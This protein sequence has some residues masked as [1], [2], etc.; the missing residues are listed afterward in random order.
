MADI[1][2]R[3]IS[4]VV[5]TLAGDEWSP[6]DPPTGPSQRITTA[7]QKAYFQTLARVTFSNAA[8]TLA[9]TTRILAQVG[10]LSAARAVTL[11]AANAVP[12]GTQI[13][14]LDESGT[15]SASNTL[16]W[17]RAGS[18]TINGGAS[19]VVAVN[20]AYGAGSIISDGTSKWTTVAFGG[21]SGSPGPAGP[22]YMT[23]DF[24]GTLAVVVGTMR[25]RIPVAATLLGVNAAVSLAPTGASIIVD[26]NKNG[27]TVFTTQGNRPTIAAAANN[28][29]A[30][31]TNMNVTSVA[32][33]D[34]LT[35]DM[36]QVGSTIPGADLVVTVRFREN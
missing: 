22:S 24:G 23:F 2:I 27:T 9:A 6:V 16:S 10:T 26:L 11:P 15:A 18:D 13:T 19:N 20:A 3:Q 21:G 25:F 33:G 17:A 8:H 29:G 14:V 28:S 35:V 31:T 7:N 36:D 1:R 12:A 34:Y 32:A 4:T 5:A 30:E